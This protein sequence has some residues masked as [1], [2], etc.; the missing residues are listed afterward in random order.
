MIALLGLTAGLS[1]FGM[2]SVLPSLPN[3]ASGFGRPYADVQFVVSVYL[4]GLGICQPFQGM[5]S[6]RFG[7]RPVLLTGFA[8]FF[9]GSVGAAIAPNL[10]VLVACRF[11]QSIGV[12]VATVITRAIVRDTHPPQDAAVTLAFVSTVMGVAPIVAPLAGGAVLSFGDWHGV[13]M[14]HAALALGLW[15][16]IFAVLRETRPAD[17]RPSG[18]GE[19]YANVR[20]LLGDRPFVG[21][22]LTYAFMSGTSF[23]F[24]TIGAALFKNLFGITPSQFGFLW[25]ILAVAFMFGSYLAARLSRRYASSRVLLAGVRLNLLS[26]LAFIAVAAWAGAPLVAYCVVLGLTMVAFGMASP[27]SLAA[28]VA[29]RPEIAGVASGL[30]SSIGMLV[31]TLFAFATGNFFDGRA[32]SVAWLMPLSCLGAWIAVNRALSR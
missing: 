12:S 5:L 2:A 7:R 24:V 11:L 8:I 9:L 13:F 28:A 17:T 29:D 15:L 4:L 6:D 14:L 30:S 26:G 19:F 1:A 18:P 20:L 31:A 27:L 22:T 16:W 10:A 23:V 32:L 3:L 25:A 21:H